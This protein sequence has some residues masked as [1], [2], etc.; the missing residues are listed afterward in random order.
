MSSTHAVC[1]GKSWKYGGQFICILGSPVIVELRPAHSLRG[2][3][4]GEG[5][6]EEQGGGTDVDVPRHRP[7]LTDRLLLVRLMKKS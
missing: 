5:G 4:K 6:T 1:S 7:H 2:N 3:G